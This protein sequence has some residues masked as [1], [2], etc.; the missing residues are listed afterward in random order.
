MFVEWF[1]VGVATAADN[2]GVLAHHVECFALLGALGIVANYVNHHA[3][4]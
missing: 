3:T 2:V 4:S 1:E